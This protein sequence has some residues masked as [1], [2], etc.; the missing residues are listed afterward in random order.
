MDKFAAIH[1]YIEINTL[2]MEGSI[3]WTVGL[4]PPEDGQLMRTSDTLHNQS[5]ASTDPP[6]RLDYVAASPLAFCCRAHLSQH[7]FH[8]IASK[9]LRQ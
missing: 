4:A 7:P 1:C 5:V 6:L 3:A 2:H 8:Q 9:G